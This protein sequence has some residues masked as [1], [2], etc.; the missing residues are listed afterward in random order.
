MITLQIEH[1]ITDLGTWQAAFDRFAEAR[2][3]AGVR[4]ERVQRPIDDPTTI[5]VDLAFDEVAAAEKFRE[6]LRQTV[7]ST[8]ENSPALA[9]GP[10][11]RILETV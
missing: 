8:S 3:N 6:F 4:G 9:G 1:P 5:V 2:R 11:T 7:W 10:R